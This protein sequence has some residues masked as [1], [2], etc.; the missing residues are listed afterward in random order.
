MGAVVLAVGLE[1]RFR[2]KLRDEDAASVVT[3]SDL[4]ELVARIGSPAVIVFGALV[5][6][7]AQITTN[8]AANVVSP[9]PTETEMF[10]RNNLTGPDADKTR[11]YFLAD[12]PMRRFARPEEVA[13]AICFFLSREA[14]FVTGQV[15]HVCGGSSVGP[16]PL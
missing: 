4:V 6:L 15:L 9:G 11:A 14:S 10:R 13:A 2:I 7:A 16:A 8:M 12:V 3:V 5:V 1:D